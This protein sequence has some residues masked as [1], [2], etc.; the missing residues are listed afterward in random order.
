MRL[1]SPLIR[2]WQRDTIG[3]GLFQHRSAKQ[4]QK[5]W[6]KSMSRLQCQF[7][8]AVERS[9]GLPTG[10]LFADRR[11]PIPDAALTKLQRTSVIPDY[12]GLQ[13]INSI[14][15]SCRLKCGMMKTITPTGL[16]TAVPPPRLS[17]I[18]LIIVCQPKAPPLSPSYVDHVQSKLDSNDL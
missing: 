16:L 4:A 18:S 17:S 3:S 15:Y 8:V 1:T 5:Q 12:S 9:A 2:L 11:S 13:I 6:S 10:R 7:F 14:L